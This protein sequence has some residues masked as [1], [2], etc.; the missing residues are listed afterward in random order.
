MS[1]RV[2]V[3]TFHYVCNHGAVLQAL[4]VA[5]LFGGELID[6]RYRRKQDYY[7]ERF[8]KRP[9]I[10]QFIEEQ[11]PLGRYSVVADDGDHHQTWQHIDKEYEL[12]VCGSDEVWKTL[13]TPVSK[14]R[15]AKWLFRRPL[16]VLRDHLAR[17][18]C[19]VATPYPN[20]YWPEGLRIPRVSFAAS[21]GIRAEDPL[22]IPENH[23]RQMARSLEQFSLIGV[24]DS[25]TK[26]WILRLQPSL[27]RKVR[28]V[29]DPVFTH[30][31][32][33]EDQATAAEWL[34]K[35]S[36][37]NRPRGF[38]HI[39]DPSR[40][41]WAVDQLR[42]S[43]LMPVDLETASLTPPQWYSAIGLCEAG[44]TDAMHPFISSLAQNV[45]CLS[46]DRRP[47]SVE[48]RTQFGVSKN[49][50][51]S[52]II[53]GWPASVPLLAAEYR[54]LAEEYAREALNLVGGTFGRVDNLTARR[55]S[56]VAGDT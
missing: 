10:K 19:P 15:F 7:E 25:A 31:S 5:K 56:R 49:E 42:R 29:P 46:I 41:D 48:L 34:D 2:A 1:P 8:S 52:E 50:D 51:L 3:V 36:P 35:Q 24:R 27:E 26:R 20:L 11:L 18:P 28:L 4:A 32:K 38:Y 12:M 54:S 17:Q 37:F 14:R 23:R 47:K 55:T 45:P 39:T 6:H 33:P 9:K 43:G 13:Y 30:I 16:A 40:R 21:A 44:V 22:P 53:W